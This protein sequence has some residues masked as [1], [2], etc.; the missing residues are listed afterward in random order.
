MDESSYA[1]GRPIPAHIV[2]ADREDLP[3][4]TPRIE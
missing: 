2:S 3:V 4:E 1:V